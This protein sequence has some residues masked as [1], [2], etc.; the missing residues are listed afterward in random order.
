MEAPNPNSSGFIS[1]L[2]LLARL[3]FV[4][5]DAVG[6]LKEMPFTMNRSFRKNLAI[7]SQRKEAFLEYGS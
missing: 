7:L 2:R 1:T 3:S 5:L 6:L 4:W